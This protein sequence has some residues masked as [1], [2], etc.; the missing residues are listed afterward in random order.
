[1]QLQEMRTTEVQNTSGDSRP[2]LW[3]DHD[4]E[5]DPAFPTPA[6]S[7]SYEPAASSLPGKTQNWHLHPEHLST[8]EFLSSEQQL[9]GESKDKPEAP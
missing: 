4:P 1:M 7:S 8:S 2:N 9:C 6:P 3:Q 5:G